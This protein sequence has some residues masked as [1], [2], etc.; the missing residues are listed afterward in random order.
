MSVS[1]Q[2]PVL[3]LHGLG[4]WRTQLREKSS[5]A[6]WPTG[7][8]SGLDGKG[9]SNEVNSISIL[10]SPIEHLNSW[11]CDIFK[12]VKIRIMMSLQCLI[13]GCWRP[14]AQGGDLKR[15]IWRDFFNFKIFVSGFSYYT[16]S[17]T[18]VNEWFLS[19][20]AYI[21]TIKTT[22]L[23]THILLFL[24]IGSNF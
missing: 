5:I 24:V 7:D 10:E 9:D 1:G 23:L 2:A 4:S 21:K 11:P 17:G 14:L 3:D 20:L 19:Q 15:N 13:S 16:Y 8:V 12:M 6:S 22:F 18:Q